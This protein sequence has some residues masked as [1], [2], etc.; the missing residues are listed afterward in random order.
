MAAPSPNS[1][2]RTSKSPKSWSRAEELADRFRKADAV[3]NTDTVTRDGM[4]ASAHY[5]HLHEHASRQLW[6]IRHLAV[7]TAAQSFAGAA[8]Q[9]GVVA[10]E[11][12]VLINSSMAKNDHQEAC[13]RIESG[14]HS[15]TDLLLEAAGLKPEEVSINNLMVRPSPFVG[16]DQMIAGTPILREDAA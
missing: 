6:A 13:R 11:F 10:T 7:T 5:Q 16:S 12:D 3:T 4:A 14:L 1:R 9:L 15:A 2:G 8:Y